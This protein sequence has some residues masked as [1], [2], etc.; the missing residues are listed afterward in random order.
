MKRNLRILV[1]L[2]V[3][4]M[5]AMPMWAEEGEELPE[6]LA[7]VYVVDVMPGHQ[8]EFEDAFKEHMEMHRQAQDTWA[9]HAWVV[10]AGQNLG[11]YIIRSAWHTWESLDNEV[12]VPNDQE[13]VATALS[14]HIDNLSSMV[15]QAMPKLSNWPE[16]LG[17]PKM[18]EVNV[19][20]LEYDGVEDFF[21]VVKKIH[22]MILEQEMPLHYSW[23]EVVV[24]ASGPQITLVMPRSG[25]AD[26]KPRDPGIWAMAEEVYGETE[27]KMMRAM[28]GD[29]IESEEHFV[30]MF[31]PDLCLIPGE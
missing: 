10:V 24:G 28:I 19:F 12:E 15:S 29:A 27:A 17:V 9:R 7:M 13:H 22:T 23:S 11:R 4:M 14:P 16:D 8:M 2:P 5:C 25:W 18:V 6:M 21:H 1:V 26:F 20:N 31:R 3:L 30:A